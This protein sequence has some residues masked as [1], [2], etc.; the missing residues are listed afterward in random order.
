MVEVVDI[1]ECPRLPLGEALALSDGAAR[2]L[3]LEGGGSVSARPMLWPAGGPEIL[4]HHRGE[5]GRAPDVELHV[6]ADG[7]VGGLG[8]HV[9]RNGAYLWAPNLWPGY[10]GHWMRADW[11]VPTWAFDDGD[12]IRTERVFSI[13]HFNLIYGHWLT[14]MLPKLFVIGRLKERGV[15]APIAWPSTAP[16]YMRAAVEELLPGQELL[17]YEPGRSYVAADRVLLPSMMQQ[18]YLFHPALLGDFQQLTPGA[19]PGPSA[20]FVSRSALLRGSA[21]RTLVNASEIEALAVELG[22]TVI[23]PERIPWREQVALFSGAELVV[24]EFGSGLHN[25]LFSPEGTRV[26]ALNWIN[27]VQSR[28]A[29]FR[30]HDLGFILDPDGEPRVFSPEPNHRGFRIDPGEFRRRVEPLVPQAARG[31]GPRRSAIRWSAWPTR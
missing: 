2:V 20:L 11:D 16:A 5:L 7:A 3:L 29:A 28:I 1:S 4:D 17:V 8:A 27:E 14:E 22:L 6:V 30:G 26:V 19:P 15:D 21:F 31:A 25:A 12:P 10:V 24:G 13:L 18:S 23:H 9:R